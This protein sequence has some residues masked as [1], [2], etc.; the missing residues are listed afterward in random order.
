MEGRRIPHNDSLLNPA[1]SLPDV[2]PYQNI[3]TYHSTLKSDT[4]QAM[5]V[6]NS[7]K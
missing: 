3:P 5:Y 6:F 2:H 1:A 7:S 4:K